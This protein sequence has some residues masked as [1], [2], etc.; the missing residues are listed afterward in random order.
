[1]MRKTFLPLCLFLAACTEAE[2]PTPPE[3]L[4]SKEVLV[5]LIVDL[6]VLEQHFHRLYMR[7]DAYAGA[8]DSS[9]FYVFESY[10]VTRDAFRN[11]INYYCQDADSLF[12]IFESAL[13]TINLRV[14]GPSAPMPGSVTSHPL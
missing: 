4:I 14:S 7:P 8:L 5:P 2:A 10:G 11:S 9:S 1:M 6:E 3:D 13:D 12:V